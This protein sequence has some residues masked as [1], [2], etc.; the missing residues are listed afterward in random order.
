MLWSA[1]NWFL[2]ELANLRLHNW[3]YVLV[4]D[5]DVARCVG[6]VLAFGTVLPGVFWIDHWLGYPPSAH[7]G[8]RAL[9]AGHERSSSLSP[10][11]C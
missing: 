5:H 6:T 8:S 11:P 1:V 7:S 10:S 3:H 2:Y 9:H 4:T